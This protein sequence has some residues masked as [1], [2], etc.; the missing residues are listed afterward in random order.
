MI[1]IVNE[2]LTAA[3]G[4]G[5][6]QSRIRMASKP[7]TV[8]MFVR[9]AGRRQDHPRRQTGRLL[10]W[11]QGKQAAICCA[12]CDVY[13]PAAID[14]LKVVGGRLEVAGV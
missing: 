4:A 7:P 14:Q 8:V 10:I 13:R 6:S 11:Q 12:A 1:K 2:E 9:A 3:D 5:T